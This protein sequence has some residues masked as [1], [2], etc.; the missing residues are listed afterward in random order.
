[1]YALRRKE[2]FAELKLCIILLSVIG[3]LL[4]VGISIKT[5][6]TSNKKI[7]SEKSGD[8]SKHQSGKI[9]T[10][11]PQSYHHIISSMSEKY[12]VESSLVYAVI[13]VESNWNYKAISKKGAIGLMQ[14]MPSTAKDMNVDNLFDP[15]ENIDGGVRYLRY[16]L[17]K[18]KGDV[19]LTLAAYNSGPTKVKRFNGM[20]PIKET[21]QYV[22][23]VLSIYNKD[24]TL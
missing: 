1:M 22:K 6:D 8:N 4:W 16:L 21:K 24:L 5:D 20:P 23:R 13:E 11:N 10:N 7:M 9:Y 12:K 2:I 19:T 17:D 3:T 15:E 14:L 18:F